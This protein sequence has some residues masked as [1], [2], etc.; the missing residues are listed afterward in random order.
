MQAKLANR[1]KRQNGLDKVIAAETGVCVGLHPQDWPWI[2]GMHPNKSVGKQLLVSDA[3]GLK[4][5]RKKKNKEK[6]LRKDLLKHFQ[7]KLNK[8]LIFTSQI[9]TS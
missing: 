4:Q 8:L 2:L 1:V 9:E 3:K 6:T 5:L 7:R